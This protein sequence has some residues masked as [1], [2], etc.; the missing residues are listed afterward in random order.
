MSSN[1]NVLQHKS[2][3]WLN[4]VSDF[5]I[6][7]GKERTKKIE[8]KHYEYMIV[9]DFHPFYHTIDDINMPRKMWGKDIVHL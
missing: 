7:R 2:L 6:L 4:S 5:H 3:K 1:F 8:S 9:M